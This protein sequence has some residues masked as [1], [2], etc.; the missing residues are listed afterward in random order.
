MRLFLLIVFVATSVAAQTMYLRNCRTR[1]IYGPVEPGKKME[2]P[3][4]Q[5]EPVTPSAEEVQSVS[6]LHGLVI[7]AVQ[8]S[9][10]PIAQVV[11]EITT[12]AQQAGATS[13][14]VTVDLDGYQWRKDV[15][16]LCGMM[17]DSRTNVPSVFLVGR[18]VSLF[19][20]LARLSEET[21]LPV[22]EIQRKIIL[23]QKNRNQLSTN[24]TEPIR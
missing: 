22:N 14:T 5:Y 23:S 15:P 21:D 11:A 7:P 18:Y 6:T 19:G 20:F 24:G 3:A 13:L 8:F 17:S 2:I 16:S 1:M 4:G 12:L 10:A 9:N